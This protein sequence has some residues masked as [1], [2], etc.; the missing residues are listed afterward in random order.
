M[1][2]RF[3]NQSRSTRCQLEPFRTSWRASSLSTSGSTYRSNAKFRFADW[4]R[5]RDSAPPDAHYA[6]PCSFLRVEVDL[7]GV[8]DCGESG[9]KVDGSLDVQVASE[10]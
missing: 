7:T 9:R 10:S 2:I 3:A 4:L 6:W 8:A 1:T 5:L